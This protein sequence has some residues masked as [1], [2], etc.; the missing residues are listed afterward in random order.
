MT[1][2]KF[3]R[4]DR[5]DIYCVIGKMEFLFPKNMALL[6]VRKMKNDLPEYIQIFPKNNIFSVTGKDNMSFLVN[7]LLL[8]G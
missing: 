7:T 1:S 6:F 4:E 5:L 8:F 2:I 3:F